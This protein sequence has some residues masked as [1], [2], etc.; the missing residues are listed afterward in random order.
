MPTT[1]KEIPPASAPRVSKGFYEYKSWSRSPR[2]NGKLVLKALPFEMTRIKSVVDRSALADQGWSLPGG[3]AAANLSQAGPRPCIPGSGLYDSYFW[4]TL[5]S[6]I[7]RAKFLGKLKADKASLGVSAAGWRQSADMITGRWN[8]VADFFRYK[9]RDYPKWKKRRPGARSL[10]QTRASDVLEN[11]FGWVPLVQDIVGAASVMC[12][13]I[14]PDWIRATHRE[15]LR[16][17]FRED[18]G[19]FVHLIEAEGVGSVTF[20]ARAVVD[21]PN[22]WL[23][24][25]LG[26]INPATVAWDLVPWSFVVNMFVNVNSIIESVTDTMGVTLTDFSETRTRSLTYSET[27]LAKPG[28]PEYRGY[29]RVTSSVLDKYRRIGSLPTPKVQFKMPDASLSL[30]VIAGSLAI[31]QVGRLEKLANKAFG[32]TG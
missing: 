14:P 25:Q 29:D 20:A 13:G 8:K 32:F 21:N 31:Q 16:Q 26:L 23:L 1:I 27:Y 19:Y 28:R 9:A 6:N 11:Q 22:L 24:N 18:N 30:A 17:R 2:V 7:V 5:M 10:A 3:P 15:V 12:N 4:D